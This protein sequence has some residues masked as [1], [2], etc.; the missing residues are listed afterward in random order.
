MIN[1]HN[2][3]NDSVRSLVRYIYVPGTDYK[4]VI[5]MLRYFKN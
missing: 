4:L 2:R 1:H 3:K 5:E